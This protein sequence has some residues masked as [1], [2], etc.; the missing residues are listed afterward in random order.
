VLFYR[1]KPVTL[2]SLPTVTP[3]L[4][5]IGVPVETGVT[6]T[7]IEIPTVTLT[8]TPTL[9]GMCVPVETG[10]MEEGLRT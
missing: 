2:I 1:L 5:G 9:V 4:V 10:V 7:L 3:T 8:V 6:V